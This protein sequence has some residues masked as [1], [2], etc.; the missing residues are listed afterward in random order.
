MTIYISG[1]MTG[2]PQHEWMRNFH[3]AEMRLKACGHTV[4]NPSVLAVTFPWMG[5]DQ[6]MAL[7]LTALSFC[8]G[9][10][11]LKNYKESKGAVRELEKAK[12]IGLKV[13]FEKN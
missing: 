7:D 4:F 1:K 9:I 10:Y 12:E 6:Y 11:M 3:R 5:Y 2:L 8:D 13:L